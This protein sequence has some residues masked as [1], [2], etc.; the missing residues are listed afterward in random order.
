MAISDNEGKFKGNIGGL[1]YRIVNG[2]TIVQSKPAARTVKQTESTKASQNDF[3]LGSNRAKILRLVLSPLIKGLQDK[4]M[5]NR[6]TTAVAAVVRSNITLPAGFR[7]L[8]D[9]QLGLLEGF[10]FNVHSPFADRCKANLR[11]EQNSLAGFKISIAPFE[12]KKAIVF[13]GLATGCTFRVLLAAIN[14]KE[15][16]YQYCGTAELNIPVDRDAV[17]ATEWVFV[18]N[19]PPDC[20]FIAACSMEFF[21]NGLF[22]PISLNNKQ[23]HPVKLI[24]LMPGQ[25]VSEQVPVP[26]AAD[27]LWHNWQP[28]PGIDGNKI[29]KR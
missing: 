1:T 18:E 21:G 8:E 4:A 6:L 15:N 29:R 20:L 12:V 9:G 3:S 17:P 2:K 5:V 24:G 26:Q 27:S 22:E 23:L 11:M 25:Q 13:P 10:E 16:R 19:L 7:D 14:F 28:I